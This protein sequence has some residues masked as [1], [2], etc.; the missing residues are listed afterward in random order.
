MKKYRILYYCLFAAI[1]FSLV[2]FF[3]GVSAILKE[4]YALIPVNG[5]DDYIWDGA[6]ITNDELL[7]VSPDENNT[8]K[9]ITINTARELVAFNK[10]ANSGISYDG[11]TIKLTHDLDLSGYDWEVCDP[12]FENYFCFDGNNYAVNGIRCINDEGFSSFFYIT[13]PNGNAEIKNLSITNS[14]FEGQIA[15]VFNSCNNAR[16]IRIENCH[17]ETS[18]IRASGLA[19]GI[20]I[21]TY[22]GSSVIDCSITKLN[23]RN[24]GRQNFLNCTGGFIA[25]MDEESPFLF[26]GTVT[27]C[28]LYTSTFYSNNF[29]GAIIGYMS[30]G[31]IDGTININDTS[32][33][34]DGISTPVKVEH[35]FNQGIGYNYDD[36]KLYAE[37]KFDNK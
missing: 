8:E 30:G 21:S 22:G 20:T 2:M 35:L 12:Y 15:A 18:K 17:A 14:Y 5:E 31:Y 28:E 9:L 10:S 11:Y 19:A 34:E 24:S 32:F 27:E 3:V 1:L 7:S 33:R 25:V 4:N 6:E 23:I 36:G 13:S 26:S 37:I 29:T 16:N